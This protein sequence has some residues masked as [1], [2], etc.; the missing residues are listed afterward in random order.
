MTLRYQY[1]PVGS[2][3]T[4]RA[5]LLN[6]IAVW[7]AAND[8]TGHPFEPLLI[9]EVDMV[10]QRAWLLEADYGHDVA[11]ACEA[12][13]GRL[14]ESDAA[15]WLHY[16]LCSSDVTD[17][18]L[19]LTLQAVTA[20]LVDIAQNAGQAIGTM[21]NRWPSE[22]VHRTHGQAAQK[23]S[24]Y[25][26]WHRAEQNIAAGWQ[27]LQVSAKRLSLPAFNGPTGNGGELTMLE[28]RSIRR[29]LSGA[30]AGSGS[31]ASGQNVGRDEIVAWT[32]SVARLATAAER[33]GRDVRLLAQTGIDEVRE[34]RGAGYRGSSSM[35]HKQ[36]PTRSERLCGLAPVVRGLVAGYQ[37][38]AAE[39]WDAHSLEHSSA[40]RVVLPQISELTGFML[41]EVREIADTLVVNRGAVADNLEERPADSYKRRNAL[42]RDGAAGD[43][44]EQVKADLDSDG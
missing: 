16:G 13:R 24:A 21:A 38:A 27:I 18:G 4:E 25:G 35:P 22:A 30:N 20:E 40:E 7:R 26:R 3:W 1:G 8:A 15:R 34:G 28:R 44:W 12:L 39:C 33:F 42:I 29:A 19:W 2:E 9:G 36:N 32:Q 6:W 31:P 14:G 10:A 37:E 23:G 17:G 5:K 11:A 43:T 41:N